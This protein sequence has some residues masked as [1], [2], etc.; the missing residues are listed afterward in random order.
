MLCKGAQYTLKHIETN[1]CGFIT[2]ICMIVFEIIAQTK[3]V[4]KS[5]RT[6]SFAIA[7]Q[8]GKT[9]MIYRFCKMLGIC[10]METCSSELSMLKFS[11]VL[12]FVLNFNDQNTK[13]TIKLATTLI[14]ISTANEVESYYRLHSA[15]I[16]KLLHNARTEWPRKILLNAMLFDCICVRLVTVDWKIYLANKKRFFPDKS[17]R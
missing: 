9:K 3:I 2:P 10:L 1:S 11:Q 15:N 5:I 14:W 13:R 7:K 17:S 16:W 4:I 8:K 12:N 6:I